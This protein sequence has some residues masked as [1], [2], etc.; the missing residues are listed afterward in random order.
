MSRYLLGL[1]AGLFLT[2]LIVSAE[3]PPAFV[4]L[5][6]VRATP[7]TPQVM[8]TIRGKSTLTLQQ[9]LAQA[10]VTSL[11]SGVMVYTLCPNTCTVTATWN[12]G[13]SSGSGVVSGP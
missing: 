6:A 8:A 12:T 3:A 10:T 2:P 4:A 9:F 13:T 1:L 11:G 5:A 7:L